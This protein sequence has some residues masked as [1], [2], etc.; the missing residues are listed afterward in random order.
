[1]GRSVPKPEKLTDR[2]VKTAAPG[3]YSDGT[4][5]G[6]M[7]V[8]RDNGSRAWVLRYQ[9]GGRRRD[10]GLG[11]Y[12]EVGLADAREKALDARRLIK[13]DGKD[14]ITER[15]RAKVKTFKEA[16][17]ALIES[18]KSGWRNAKHAA[19]W[20]STLETYAYPKL[21]ALGVQTVDTDAVLDVL[22]PIWTTKTET[23]SRVR[24]RI[25]AV[26]DYATAIR[27]RSGENPA[28]WKGHLDNL[29]PKP[30]KVRT[31]KHHAALDWRQAPAFMAELA[32]RQGIDARALAFTILTVARSGEVRGMK[33]REVD[34]DDAVWTVP[35]DRIKAGREHRVPLQPAAI[36]LLGDPGE[37]DEL[38]FPSPIKA[39]KPLSDAT[40][41]A[42]L[43]RMGVGVTVHGFRSTFRDWAGETTAHAREV[44]EAALAHRLKDKAEAAYARGDLFQKRRKLMQD[45]ADYLASPA[46][47]VLELQEA[48]LEQAAAK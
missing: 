47:K 26:L 48:P 14:P 28:R 36:A 31:V 5:K 43:E 46:A 9:I 35:P 16:A 45:W 15:G 20:S 12:P 23:A 8:V 42:V 2:T 32:K 25:E 4:V 7:L 44:V 40:L 17:K 30:S 39:G 41:A 38:V 27:A 13:R 10:M 18:K 19:Q 21:G 37:P 6:L 34:L 11:P 3:R 1:V 29:L 24:Q 33:W 22:R